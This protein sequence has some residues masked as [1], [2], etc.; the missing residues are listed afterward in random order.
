MSKPTPNC[1]CDLSK[2]DFHNIYCHATT[3]ENGGKKGV[4]VDQIFYL[5]SRVYSESD[6]LSK[7]VEDS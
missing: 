2:I 5:M 1:G 7:V 6:A 3:S 4:G